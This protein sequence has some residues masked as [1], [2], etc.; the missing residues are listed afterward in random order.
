MENTEGWR[1]SLSSSV[2]LTRRAIGPAEIELQQTAPGT[3]EASLNYLAPGDPA[4]QVRIYP[5][6]SGLPTV[7]T[8][9][10]K[11]LVPIHD[12]RPKAKTLRLDVHGFELHSGPTPFTSYFDEGAVRAA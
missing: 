5:P 8:A 11:H 10:A 7:Q 6:S 4:P 2:A 1:A 9:L 12:I 3:I